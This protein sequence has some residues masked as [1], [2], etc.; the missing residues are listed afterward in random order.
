MVSVPRFRLL[1]LV[2]SRAHEMGKRLESIE[3]VPRR[4]IFCGEHG[5]LTREHAIPRWVSKD[6]FGNSLVHALTGAD[7][8][9]PLRAY[10]SRGTAASPRVVCRRCNNGWLHGLEEWARQAIGPI[11]RG[12]KKALDVGDQQSAA[13]WA[14]KTAIVLEYD[15]P[16]APVIPEWHAEYL[17]KHRVLPPNSRAWIAGQRGSD[18]LGVHFYPLAHTIVI[19]G[20]ESFDAIGY[21]VTLTVGRAVLQVYGAATTDSFVLHDQALDSDG[22]YVASIWP[23]SQTVNWPV[24]NGLAYEELDRFAHRLEPKPGDRTL[25]DVRGQTHET[26]G[27]SPSVG[28]NQQS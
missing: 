20:P 2:A 18:Q 14:L 12:R 10:T 15:R 25:V 7:G 23:P 9:I 26:I 1:L 5:P 11:M 13:L 19:R 17:Y 16:V 6:V 27:F 21:V 3:S 28:D 8:Q 24:E 4:C 22:G